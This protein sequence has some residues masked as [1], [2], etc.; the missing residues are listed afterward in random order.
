MKKRLAIL[1]AVLSCAT[2]LIAGKSNT[3]GYDKAEEAGLAF[4]RVAFGLDATEA[5]VKL[6]TLPNIK[7]IDQTKVYAQNTSSGTCYHVAVF[8]PQANY[9]YYTA[10]VNPITGVAYRAQFARKYIQLTASQKSKADLIGTLEAFPDF[11]FSSQK[12]EAIAAA[13]SYVETHFVSS[14]AIKRVFPQDIRTDSEIFP[15][16]DV[17]SLLLMADGTV[18]QVTVCWPSMTVIDVRILGEDQ[19]A[20]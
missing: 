11:D 19:I 10:E 5:K 1:L 9:P 14:G 17:D 20:E 6:V 15:M 16:V 18:Y 4:L 8:D 3:V 12:A 13:Q 2:L 7:I